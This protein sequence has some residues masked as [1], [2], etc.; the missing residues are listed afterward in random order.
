MRQSSILSKHR[1][2]IFSELWRKPC[3][4][5]K[6]IMLLLHKGDSYDKKMQ[7]TTAQIF[8]VITALLNRK[9][10]MFCMK[11]TP[12]S[13]FDKMAKGSTSLRA[14]VGQLFLW[15]PLVFQQ[16]VSDWRDPFGFLSFLLPC[17]TSCPHYHEH[18]CNASIW[19]NTVNIRLITQYLIIF[20]PR[21]IRTINH[22]H[23]QM[24]TIGLQ[25]FVCIK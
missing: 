16:A 21:I 11:Q 2:A 12:L 1:H 7:V 3:K 20:L 9:W 18:C 19:F 13:F 8:Y 10:H 14:P 5:K 17:L 6:L 4:V 22:I 23:Q 25:I 24:H 15:K